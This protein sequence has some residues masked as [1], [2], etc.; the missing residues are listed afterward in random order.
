MNRR[1]ILS[2]GNKHKVSEIKGILK[3]MPF[4][5][6]S[7]DDLGYNDFDVE[8]NGTTLEENALKKATELHNLTKGIVIA[9]DTGL[10]VDELNGD[11]GVYSARYAGEPTSD[12]NNRE[13]LLKNLENVA[14]EKRTA[15]FKTVIAIVLEDG[16]KM[17]AEG[18][19]DG[20]I[21]FKEKGKNG[22]GYDSLFIAEDTGRT[23][24]EMTDY[25]KNKISHRAR[26][27]QNLKKSLEEYI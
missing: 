16:S 6:I 26:A 14:F 25:E 12:K 10:F 3:D 9:D 27:L 7:K 20:T 1:I 17:T 2:S 15:Y 4:E 21:G 19:V 5:V 8:E 11:P 24:A 13:L 22:F 23:F 18:K